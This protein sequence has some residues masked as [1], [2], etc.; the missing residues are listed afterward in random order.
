MWRSNVASHIRQGLKQANSE[1]LGTKTTIFEV[2][3]RKRAFDDSL[4][5][6]LTILPFL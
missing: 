6:K 2:Q 1:S 5:T 4:R 3:G